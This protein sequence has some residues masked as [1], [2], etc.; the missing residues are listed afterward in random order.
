M[1]DRTWHQGMTFS[2]TPRFVQRE[3]VCVLGTRAGGMMDKTWHQ[4]MAFS[5]TPRFKGR[6]K[7]GIMVTTCHQP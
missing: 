2:F 3:Q 5:F 6:E 7:V 4:G 1:M